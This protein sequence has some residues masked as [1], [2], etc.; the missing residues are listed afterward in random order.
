MTTA[1]KLCSI[2]PAVV[3]AIVAAF[4]TTLTAQPTAR[5]SEL[6]SLVGRAAQHLQLRSES[7]RSNESTYQA[8]RELLQQTL[9]AWNASARTDQDADAM[10]QWL[11]GVI[12]GSMLG[13]RGALPSPPEF[14]PPQVAP[15]AEVVAA[16]PAP[17]EPAS[18][19]AYDPAPSNPLPVE[20][21]TFAADP[22]EVVAPERKSPDQPEPEYA[23][24]P[25][26]AAFSAPEPTAPTDAWADHPAAQKLDWSDPFA[27]DGA[28][29]AQQGV[30]GGSKRFKPV[31]RSQAVKIDLLELSTRV[32]GYNSRLRELEGLLVG[33]KELSAFRLAAIVRDLDELND[34]R[35]FLQLYLAGLSPEEADVGPR[36]QSAATLQRLIGRAVARR[37]DQLADMNGGRVE[38]ESAILSALDRKLDEFDVE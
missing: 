37:S 27:D 26:P 11:K 2:C 32:A 33:A 8:N 16:E 3:L 24:Q 19:I 7:H 38:A 28:R 4:P 22:I 34:Q 17:A 29:V 30:S 36:L 5:T 15:V 9:D 23:A 21:P 13:G 1:P 31:S 20:P 25:E 6:Q 35:N 18:P 10:E 12:R 14:L